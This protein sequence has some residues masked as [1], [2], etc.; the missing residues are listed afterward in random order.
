MMQIDERLRDRYS[1][2]SPQEQRV[3]DFI[4]DHFDDLISY[5]S[6]ELARLSGVSKATVSRLFKRLGYPSYRDMRDELRTLRQS[7]MPLADNRDAVQGNTLLAR[8]YKQEMANLTQWINQIDPVQFGAVIQALMQA[9]RVC[10]IGLRNSYPVALHLR[11]QLLQI[12]QQVTLLTQP[13]QT[14]SEELVDLTAQDVVI[15]VAFR[16]RSR[17][18]Q[19]LLVQLQKRGVPVLLLCEP[20]VSTLMSLATWS[21]CV[22]L[23]SVSAFD[24]YSSAMSLVNVISNALLHEMLRDGR[25]RIHQIVDLYGELDELEQR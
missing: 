25:Q 1:E 24:S 14:L 15:V 4:F 18:I 13:G 11:Q 23:D 22:P 17:L 3:A 16:R 6:A 19:P 10:L 8:H 9:Q 2:L 20:Q 12:R 21:L 7:G 5:N